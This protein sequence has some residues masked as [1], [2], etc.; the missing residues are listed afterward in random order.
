MKFRIAMFSAL[1]VS[2]LQASVVHAHGEDKPGPHKGFIRMPGPFHTEVMQSSDH[3]IKVYLLDM[4][5]KNP[6][7]KDSSVSVTYVSKSFREQGHC[8]VEAK[9]HYLCRF[10]PRVKLGSPG[11]LIVNAVRNNVKGNAAV[12]ELPLSLL[13]PADP[14]A[15][16]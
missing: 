3:K 2:F 11:E 13:A 12:Y 5:F 4:A 9:N 6:T 7:T 16:H 15:G 10:S 8:Q 14:H 1:C